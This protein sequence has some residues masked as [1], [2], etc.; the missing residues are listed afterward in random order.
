VDLGV[1]NPHLEEVLEKRHRGHQLVELLLRQPG[2]TLLP[3]TV[4]GVSP[5][6][7]RMGDLLRVS[8]GRR[9]GFANR[10]DLGLDLGFARGGPN[11]GEDSG[12]D[13]VKLLWVDEPVWG[14]G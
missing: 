2:L 11:Q 6:L 4:S 5:T 12:E 7:G 10:Y 8:R 3:A 1:E 9:V 14:W 13:C